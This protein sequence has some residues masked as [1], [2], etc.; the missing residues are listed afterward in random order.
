MPRLRALFDVDKILKQNIELRMITVRQNV[1]GFRNYKE[2]LK[3]GLSGN[4]INSS[5]A[6]KEI[7]MANDIDVLTREFLGLLSTIPK[8]NSEYIPI[9][10]L[11]Q[12]KKWGEWSTRKGVYY[13]QDSG[14]IVYVGLALVTLGSRVNDQ[15]NAFGDPQWDKVIRNDDVMVGVIP[16]PE[17][18][19]FISSAFEA[20]L[21]DKLKPNFNKR[22]Q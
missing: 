13:F 3:A 17:D 19:W 4:H 6:A 7:E 8:L 1:K 22:R 18:C 5:R 20:F 2:N 11:R 16:F 10:Q 21:I 15:I 14:V 12:N 9:G